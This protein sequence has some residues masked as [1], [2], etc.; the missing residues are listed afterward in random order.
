MQP[1]E[2][3]LDHD[4]WIYNRPIQ[5]EAMSLRKTTGRRRFLATASAA[6]TAS[7]AGCSAGNGDD[8]GNGQQ[9]LHAEDW[10]GVDEILLDGY[11]RNW[12]GVAPDPIAGLTNPTLLLFDGDSYD[13]TWENQ[14]GVGH[15]IELWNADDEVV[16]DN[17]TSQL[18]Q[19]GRTQTLSFAASSEMH[20]Y[21]CRPHPRN[22][23]GY[24]VVE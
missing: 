4:P 11:T 16:G 12:V 1:H 5:S 8:E 17:S 3:R 21:V 15:N 24:I 9:E 2:P 19:R 23:I 13:I 18:A 14:D 7:V 22:M 6:V 20:S 10:E